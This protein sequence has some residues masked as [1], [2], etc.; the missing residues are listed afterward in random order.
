MKPTRIALSALALSLLATPAVAQSQDWDVDPL[1]R[2]I[3]AGVAGGTAVVGGGA[4]TVV[5]APISK[6]GQHAKYLLHGQRGLHGL[7]VTETVRHH[8]LL[9]VTRLKVQA[10]HVLHAFAQTVLHT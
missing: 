9:S 3:V 4:E 5:L 8:Q 10:R 1:A 6:V 2:R 7:M